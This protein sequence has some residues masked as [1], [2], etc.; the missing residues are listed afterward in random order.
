MSMRIIAALLTCL[1]WLTPLH[2]AKAPFL[3]MHATPHGQGFFSVFTTVLGLLDKYD[4]GDYSG[5]YLN[6]GKGGFYYDPEKGDDWWSYYFQPIDQ[7]IPPH[8]LKPC[9]GQTHVHLAINCVRNLSKQRCHELITKYI[10]LKPHIQ[11]TLDRFIAANFKDMFVLG[12]HYRGTD[13]ASEAPRLDYESVLN[14]ISLY[15]F[16]HTGKE[17][18]IF[19]A[20]DEADFLEEIT[21]RFPNQ[22]ISYSTNRS[23]NGNPL[24]KARENMYKQGEEALMDCL[25]LS[26]CDHLIR[27]SSNLSLCSTYFNPQLPVDLLNPGILDR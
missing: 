27:T 7:G 19:V 2:A 25:L 26:R 5:I 11:K 14:A 16:Y 12:V 9:S 15:S 8:N 1:L 6:F 18:R 10:R 21:T 24:H 20:T 17:L 13:K 4:N 23:I 3:K 22:V